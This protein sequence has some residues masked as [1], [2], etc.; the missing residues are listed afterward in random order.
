MLNKQYLNSHKKY[1]SLLHIARKPLSNKNV[2]NSIMNI[3]SNSN[4]LISGFNHQLVPNEL[5]NILAHSKSQNLTLFTNVNI[6]NLA[7][8]SLF[9]ANRKVK[10]IVT[11][12]EGNRNYNKV[13]TEMVDTTTFIKAC[14]TDGLGEYALIR[15]HFMDGNSC[16]YWIGLNMGSILMAK[17][18]KY[19]TIA[20]V[21]KITHI[22]YERAFITKLDKI[23]V[24]L[25]AF[26]EKDLKDDD[27]YYD[28]TIESMIRR[29]LIELN[30]ND[31]VYFSKK[32]MF[33]FLI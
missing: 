16:H 31:V 28:L 9:N 19:F 26:C 5:I 17:W 3:P 27:I 21:D 18:A 14:S 33:N 24:S 29:A 20:Q 8:E 7:L 25:S 1:L 22:K 15:S 13:K 30:N 6:S 4:V 12:F 10:R 23:F 32:V 11:C 2:Q